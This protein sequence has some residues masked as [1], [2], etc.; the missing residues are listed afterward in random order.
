MQHCIER[1]GEEVWQWLH[2]KKAHVFIAGS[3]HRLCVCVSS[4][5]SVCVLQQCQAHASGGTGGTV[6]RVRALGRTVP[7]AG[8]DLPLPPPHLTQTA[9]GDMDLATPTSPQ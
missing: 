4:S 5:E 2:H 6:C 1:E 9:A 8:A 3:V 7:A